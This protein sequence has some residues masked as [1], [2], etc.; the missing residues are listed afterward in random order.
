MGTHALYYF[1]YLPALLDMVEQCIIVHAVY[2]CICI[3]IHICT[4]A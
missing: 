4:S 3:Q 2:I 1:G